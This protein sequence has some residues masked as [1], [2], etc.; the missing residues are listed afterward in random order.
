MMKKLA[1]TLVELLVVIAIIAILAAI[2]FPAFAR[3]RE[4]ARR[5]SCLSNTKQLGLGIMQYVQDYDT[6]Y[7]IGNTTQTT[8][9][10]SYTNGRGY[11]AAIFPYVKSNQIFVCPSDTGTT[12]T[13]TSTISY[14]F[15]SN[16]AIYADKSASGPS[17]PAVTNEAKLVA[18]VKTVILFEV[19]GIGGTTAAFIPSQSESQSCAGAGYNPPQPGNCN[20]DTGYLGNVNSSPAPRFQNQV[21]RHLEGAN[22]TFADGHAKWLRPLTVRGGDNWYAKLAGVCGNSTTGGGVASSVNCDRFQATFSIF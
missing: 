7:P 16:M 2:L 19:T 12:A 22:Y 21:G 9:A 11:A 8:S 10:T 17:V 6:L 20:Y 13:P 3:A 14:G 5:S 1:F 18:P 15:N 4:N